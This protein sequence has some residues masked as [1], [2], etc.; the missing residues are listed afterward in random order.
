MEAAAGGEDRGD[1]ALRPEGRR[2]FLS[3]RGATEPRRHGA[4]RHSNR[5]PWCRLVLFKERRIDMAKSVE[6]RFRPPAFVCG[7]LAFSGA[8]GRVGAQ[9]PP[10]NPAPAAVPASS[11]S[12]PG[13]AHR[14]S[15]SRTRCPIV[16]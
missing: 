11:T 13:V 12:A 2:V 5:H 6:S 8:V 1:D 16:K 10:A 7:V 3:D 14:G 9:T 4:N 15:H